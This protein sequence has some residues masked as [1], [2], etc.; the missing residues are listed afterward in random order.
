MAS[1]CTPRLE[2]LEPSHSDLDRTGMSMLAGLPTLGMGLMKSR[3]NPPNLNPL[4][5]CSVNELRH[6]V[7]EWTQTDV[8][9]WLDKIML[10]NLRP[11]FQV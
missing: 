11:I 7:C 4:S 5:Y 1:M 9:L 8:L 6:P 3:H 10:G 2:P